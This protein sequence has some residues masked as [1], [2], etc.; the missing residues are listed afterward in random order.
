MNKMPQTYQRQRVTSPT[1]EMIR[2]FGKN[3]A[4][5]SVGA[6][7]MKK[8]DF[9]R[10][11]SQLPFTHFIT[12][13]PT[14]SS[15]MAQDEVVQRMRTIEFKL[16]KKYL[17]N[18]FTRRNAY[19]RLWMMG[20]PEGDGLSHQRHFH[21]LLHTPPKVL[22]KVSVETIQQ[23]IQLEWLRLPAYEKTEKQGRIYLP[24][25]IECLDDAAGA[26]IYASKWM[27]YTKWL[28]RTSTGNGWFFTSPADVRKRLVGSSF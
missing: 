10:W 8:M 19:D 18:T 11:I 7:E 17:G 2:G 23:S 1:A 24:L 22:S 28:E 27:T 14:P 26:A 6:A 4:P 25:H 20:F 12:I 3:I 5:R 15:P 21:L 9:Q 13:E 16:N